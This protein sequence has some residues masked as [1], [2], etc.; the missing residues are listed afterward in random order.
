MYYKIT[1]YLHRLINNLNFL[2]TQMKFTRKN[3]LHQ[4]A[5]LLQLLLILIITRCKI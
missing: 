5:I 2:V 1:E 3:L 4:K